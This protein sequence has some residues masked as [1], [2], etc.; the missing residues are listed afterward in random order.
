MNR[1]LIGLLLWVSAIFCLS[2]C[3]QSSTQDPRKLTA[4]V[5][6]EGSSTMTDLVQAWAKE[7]MKTHPS[8]PV[9]V[10]SDDSGSGIAALLNRTTDLAASS[11]DLTS[12]E[13]RL[14][15]M[16]GVKVKRITVARDAIAVIVNPANPVES[17]TL[18]QLKDIFS[19]DVSDWS[20]VGDGKHKIDLYSREESSGTHD[21]FQEHVLKGEDFASSVNVVQGSESLIEA[22]EKNKWSI[23][24]VG[25]G[26]A[27][28]AEKQIKILKLKLMA[29]SEAVAP[30][31]SSSTTDYPLSR[32]LLML[33]DNNPKESVKQ[34]VDF[35]LSEEGQKL[36]TGS[37]YVT[38][39]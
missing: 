28:K 35:C 27:L 39:R 36:V 31:G 30:S 24:Y 16:K 14:A 20:A 32:P 37:G 29:S 6:V 4:L 9:S 23:A 2:A 10:N 3:E 7:F 34:F 19:G 26:H 25:L 17:L 8:V 38:L 11:R 22:V 12:D 33:M 18:S 1:A 5:A 21:Y 15:Q 13:S